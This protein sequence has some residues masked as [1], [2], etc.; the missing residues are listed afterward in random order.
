M[1]LATAVSISHFIQSLCAVYIPATTINTSDADI[2]AFSTRLMYFS[3]SEFIGASTVTSSLGSTL[4]SSLSGIST[5]TAG[6]TGRV[7]GLS[8]QLLAKAQ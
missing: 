8:P 3:S 5:A 4:G 7:A 1:L 6:L 2:L